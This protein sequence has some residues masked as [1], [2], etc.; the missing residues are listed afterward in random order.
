[1]VAVTANAL[2]GEEEKCLAA[3]MDAYIAKPV[4]IDRLRTTLERWVAI[5]LPPDAE[6]AA[7]KPQAG[8]ALDPGGPAARP[9]GDPAALESPFSQVRHTP[10]Q[11]PRHIHS[12]AP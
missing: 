5:Q 4:N 1:M 7:E 2:K 6:G 9:R 10:I 12:A 11:N 3:G 8:A